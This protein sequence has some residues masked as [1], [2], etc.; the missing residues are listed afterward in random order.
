MNGRLGYN[1]QLV[2]LWRTTWMYVVHNA[3]E[4]K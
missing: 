4:R 2:Y 1:K 3:T